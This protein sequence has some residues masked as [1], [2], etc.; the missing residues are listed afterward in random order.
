MNQPNSPQFGKQDGHVSKKGKRILYIEDNQDA[1]EMM[2]LILVQAGYEVTTADSHQIN[3]EIVNG[4]GFA[5]ILLESWLV[6]GSG[7]DLCKAIRAFDARIPIVFFTTAAFEKDIEKAMAAGADAYLLKPNDV[8]RI[9][10]TI[11]HL[12]NLK[13]MTP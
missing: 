8:S 2:G 9:I 5:L 13:T 11:T 1:A 4:G 7:T 12:L 3:M 6:E 10:P